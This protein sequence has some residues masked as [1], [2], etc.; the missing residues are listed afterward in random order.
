MYLGTIIGY[1][2]FIISTGFVDTLQN[3]I[4]MLCITYYIFRADRIVTRLNLATQTAQ[5]DKSQEKQLDPLPTF[6]N[7]GAWTRAHP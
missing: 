3:T 6:T 4:F 7:S 5:L 1:I 2:I